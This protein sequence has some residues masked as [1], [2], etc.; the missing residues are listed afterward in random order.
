MWCM[1]VISTDRAP[2]PAGHYSQAI[3]HGDLIFVAGQL[4]IGPDGPMTDASIEEQTEQALRNV[5][6]ILEAAGSDLSHVL[7]ATVY[8]PDVAHWGRINAV[9]AEV[10]GDHKPARVV[11]PTRDL[12]HGVLVEVDVIAARA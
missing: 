6:A 3:V 1:E 7:R 5:A 11:V 4:P 10:F 8:I 2:T 9:Y 12:H